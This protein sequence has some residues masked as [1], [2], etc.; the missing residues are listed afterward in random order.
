MFGVSGS[1]KT[2]NLIPSVRS[3]SFPLS[4]PKC[5]EK[6]VEKYGRMKRRGKG[7]VD[8]FWGREWRLDPI[9]AVRYLG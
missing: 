2:R 5:C 4:L 1:R 8:V 7:G 9:A 6:T 3:L